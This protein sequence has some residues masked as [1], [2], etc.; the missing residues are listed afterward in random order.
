MYKVMYVRF[1]AFQASSQDVQAGSTTVFDKWGNDWA[2][3]LAVS[4]A[5]QHPAWEEKRK[6]LREL[7]TTMCVQRMMVDIIISG[8]P[9]VR[10]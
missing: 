10:I 2:D 7:R 1:P 5:A 9:G 4:G 3:T 6:H 8:K